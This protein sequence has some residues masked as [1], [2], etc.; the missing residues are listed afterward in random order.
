MS[1]DDASLPTVEGF[2]DFQVIGHG[3]F[4]IVYSATQ[5]DF[6]RRVAVKVLNVDPAAVNR[7]RRETHALGALDSIPNVVQAYQMLT[8]AD[9]RLA[10]VM[11]LMDTS[12]AT[13]MSENGRLPFDQVLAWTLH[14][15]AALQAAHDR[16][17]HHRDIKPANVLLSASEAFLADFG[18]ATLADLE[19]STMTAL[20]LSPLFAPPER[21]EWG[22]RGSAIR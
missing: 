7:L 8:L 12:L 18:I 9:G 13:Q 2:T 10:I 16:G 17:I 11:R 21:L 6:R 3:G 1:S 5:T 19:T 20:S 22:H 4:S 14:I 15:G